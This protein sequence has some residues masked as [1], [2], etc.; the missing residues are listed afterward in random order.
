[1]RFLPQSC[2]SCLNP[3]RTAHSIAHDAALLRRLQIQRTTHCVHVQ[4]LGNA[5]ALV[6]EERAW[7]LHHG[8]V[9]LHLRGGGGSGCGGHGAEGPAPAQKSESP[10]QGMLRHQ[11]N[12]GGARHTAHAHFD[13]Q[14]LASKLE[15]LQARYELEVA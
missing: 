12:T 5:H 13:A 9:P 11:G 4:A 3:S 7:R 2:P 15:S 14:T 6:M 8:H 10:W 1:M